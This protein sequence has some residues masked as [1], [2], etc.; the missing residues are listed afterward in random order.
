MSQLH[1]VRLCDPEGQILD[2]TL[3]ISYLAISYLT[4]FYL[5]IR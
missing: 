2:H 4:V 5:H 1:G 3:A